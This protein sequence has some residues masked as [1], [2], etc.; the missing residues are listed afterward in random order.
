[1]VIGRSST[2]TPHCPS[3]FSA[4]S[5]VMPARMVSPTGGVTTVPPILNRMFIDP[6]SSMNRRSAASSHRT[7]VK[8]RASASF[9]ALRL[10][11]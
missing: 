5:L 6:T 4:E 7:W 1:M 9:S 2:G 11:A 10:A 3:S 8:P